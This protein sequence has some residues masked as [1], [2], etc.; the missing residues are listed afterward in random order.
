VPAASASS[1]TADATDPS[2]WRDIG[3]VRTLAA[4]ERAAI[5]RAIALC[6]GNVPRAAGVLG[7]SPSTLYR[8]R[9]AWAAEACPGGDATR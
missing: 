1:A 6:D 4:V 5:E 8:K 3:D 9:Q 7:V 2:A